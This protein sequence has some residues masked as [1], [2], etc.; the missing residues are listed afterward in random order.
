[1]IY[2]ILVIWIIGSFL[3]GWLWH[4]K[5]RRFIIGFL[6]SV[7][8]S[9]IIGMIITML[10]KD[11]IKI[12]KEREAKRR[13]V[14]QDLDEAYDQYLQGD[15]KE[16]NK[17]AINNEDD[18]KRVFGLLHDGYIDL[19]TLRLEGS[20]LSMLVKRENMECSDYQMKNY[21]LFKSFRVPLILANLTFQNVDS[22]K[23][24]DDHGI[25]IYSISWYTLKDNIM[26]IDFNEFTKLQ[27]K[28]TDKVIGHLGD[29]KN[30]KEYGGSWISP[31]WFKVPKK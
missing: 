29:I 2:G 27:I 21:V 12:L 14:Y 7:F 24:I 23:I 8:I 3:Q 26:Y 4:E 18:I 28:F 6:I 15:Y 19:N 9:P 1:M 13:A 16:T 22:F 20:D 25:V 11:N 31:F 17:I 10:I 30:L 5:G